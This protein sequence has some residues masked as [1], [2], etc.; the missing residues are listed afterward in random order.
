MAGR[1]F[2]LNDAELGHD[3]LVAGELED[4][5]NAQLDL[6]SLE[7]DL[8]PG[9]L[10]VR[11]HVELGLLVVVHRH[12]VELLLL[13]VPVVIGFFFGFSVLMGGQG[14]LAVVWLLFFGVLDQK[15]LL[16][17]GAVQVARGA[18][19]VLEAT[20][21]VGVRDV[22]DQQVDVQFVVVLGLPIA[23][24]AGHPEFGPAIL[25]EAIQHI[26]FQVVE[27]EEFVF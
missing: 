1:G 7:L 2:P 21:L 14:I 13:F 16:D 23:Q 9:A 3:N 22:R 18:L 11:A 26:V 17:L 27:D 5:G 8:S 19:W 24:V 20:E 25:G 15:V 12:G 10:F 4:P 6:D